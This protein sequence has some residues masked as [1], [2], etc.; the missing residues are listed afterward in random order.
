MFHQQTYFCPV[1][2]GLFLGLT[3]RSTRENRDK[4]DAAQQG[5]FAGETIL[6]VVWYKGIPG[7][8]NS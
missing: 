1:I 5:L 8:Q 3:Y 7:V 6:G 4:Q 2:L